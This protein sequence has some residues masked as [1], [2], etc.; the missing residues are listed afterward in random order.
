MIGEYHL[1]LRPDTYPLDGARCADH[2]R[3]RRDALAKTQ[4]KLGKAKLARLLRW[5]FTLGLWGR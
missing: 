5:V 4:R 1:T 3:W 2:V